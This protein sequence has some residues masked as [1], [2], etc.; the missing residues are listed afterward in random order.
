MIFFSFIRM[1]ALE[2][3]CLKTAIPSDMGDRYVTRDRL[4]RC[5]CEIACSKAPS[6]QLVRYDSRIN[7]PLPDDGYFSFYVFN[8]Q[9]RFS[10]SM[11][12]VNT[13]GNY[14]LITGEVDRNSFRIETNIEMIKG[15]IESKTNLVLED[16]QKYVSKSNESRSLTM[17]IREL[18]KGRRCQPADKIPICTA[19][20]IAEQLE[21]TVPNTPDYY[22]EKIT[23]Y[24]NYLA[25][26]NGELD[27]CKK[28]KNHFIAIAKS[29]TEKLKTIKDKN[30]RVEGMK[31][32]E[33]YLSKATKYSK[34][35][36]I[37]YGLKKDMIALI[38]TNTELYIA[39][40]KSGI[41][42]K[43]KWMRS[44][45]T[46]VASN[47]VIQTAKYNSRKLNEVCLA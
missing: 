34:I 39:A 25:Q 11:V 20:E 36:N 46:G 29:T 32:V 12:I 42:E 6:S 40:K 31:H 28:A 18:K 5:L 45:L 10:H 22:M 23:K 19:S 16:Y 30:A 15:Y 37:K 3:L 24:K 44:I 33:R 43:N 4:L 35:I 8:M 1:S 17:Q 21:K 27:K 9:N 14:K 7:V 26:L 41:H 13:G 38:N 2:Q 47:I